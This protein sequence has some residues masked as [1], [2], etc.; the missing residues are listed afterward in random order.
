ERALDGFGPQRRYG[1][2]HCGEPW[3]LWLD[4]DEMLDAVALRGIERA[5]TNGVPAAGYR[6]AR[7]TWFLGRR[8]RFCGWRGEKVLRL[9]RR[10]R[11]SFDD[12]PVHEQVRVEGT[13]ADL[14][15]ILEH[16]SYESWEECR[17]K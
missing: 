8:I 7:R 3:V 2:E 5:V 17:A 10:D 4:A 15:G 1:L 12:A 11:A 14:P 6:V 9:F 16:R 13:V